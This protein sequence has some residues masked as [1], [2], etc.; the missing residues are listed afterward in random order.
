MDGNSLAATT[1]ADLARWGAFQLGE[2]RVDPASREVR[3]P[4]GRATIEPRVMQVLLVLVG[5]EGAVVTRD[6]LSRLCWNSRIVGDDALNRAI[7][8]V[9]RLARSVAAEGFGVET[10]PRTG[11]RL[12]GATVGRAA[13]DLSAR[14]VT[15]EARPPAQAAGTPLSSRRWLL[16]GGALALAAAGAGVWRFW[17]DD[18]AR[19]AGDLAEQARLSMN[20]GL[21]DGAGRGLALLRQAVA[22]Q[23]RDPALWGKLALA[24]RAKSEFASPAETAPAVRACEFAAAHALA[25][26]PKQAD[27]RT[28]LIM[29]RSAYGDWLMVERGLRGVLADSPRHVEA[30]GELAA[31]FQSVGRVGACGEIIDSLAQRLPLSPVYQYRHGFS[32]WSRGRQGDADRALDRA[33]ALWP[34]HPNVWFARLWLSAFTGRANAALSQIDDVETRPADMTVQAAALLR[35]SMS[36]LQ[37]RAP[38]AVQA[39]VDANLAAARAGPG[40]SVSAIMTLAGLGRLDEAF[41]VANSYLLRQGASIGPLRARGAQV[42]TTDTRHRHTQVLF[43]PVTEPL[44]ADPRF[45]PM[46][47]ACGLAD[48]WRAAGRWPDF[49]GVR[50][51]T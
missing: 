25:L 9:R 18:R 15:T 34:R 33:M 23:P 38:A 17:P 5:A 26:D 16:A 35:T 51:L 14:V 2:T 19:R 37:S 20:D 48:Y 50:R 31:L 32:L 29:L 30:A 11:Y 1:A 46:C 42:A 39:A 47:E 4:G 6:E 22:L 7:G 8:E 45:L 40:G 36:A 43:V 28:A 10:I 3:G 13:A 41:T 24:W 12:T 21:A 44:R 27:A 49:L